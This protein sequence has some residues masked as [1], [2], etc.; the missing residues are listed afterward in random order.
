MV[1]CREWQQQIT[2]GIWENQ[3]FYI[4][5]ENIKRKKKANQPPK[6]FLV[7]VCLLRAPEVWIV[8]L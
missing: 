4:S 6:T 3:Y 5:R 2:A 7:K 1:W 8:Q